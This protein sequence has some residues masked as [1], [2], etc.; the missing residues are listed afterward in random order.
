MLILR[1]L[2]VVRGARRAL[3]Y[4]LLLLAFA[5][6]YALYTSL[7]RDA[8]GAL[9]LGGLSALAAKNVPYVFY[10]ALFEALAAHRPPP[11][12]SHAADLADSECRLEGNYGLNDLDK[13]QQLS[14]HNLRHC[15]RVSDEQFAAL[16]DS[17]AGFVRA[18][19]TTVLPRIDALVDVGS[20]GI[21]TVGGA[22][23]SVLLLTMLAQL[24]NSGTTLPVEVFIPPSDEGDDEFCDKF[25]PSF[26]ARC[27]RFSDILPPHLVSSLD[28][29]SYQ[30]KAM[31]LVMSRFEHVLFLDADNFAM[32]DLDGVFDTEAY[33]DTGLVIWPDLWRRVTAP[34][35][36]DIANVSVDLDTR[37]RYCYDDV[38]P[39]SRY[40]KQGMDAR[41]ADSPI[42]FHDLRGTI[43]DPASESGQMLVDKRRHAR[44]LLLALYYNIHGPAWYYRMFSQGTAGEGDKETFVSAAHALRLPYYQVRTPLAFDGFHHDTKAFQGL[45]LLQHDFDQDYALHAKIQRQMQASH[46]EYARY[47]PGYNVEASF[48]EPFLKQ[49]GPHRDV[50]VDVMFLH[51]SFYKFDPWTLYDQDCFMTGKTHE[52]L[53]GY[54][55]QRRYDF[56]DFELFNFRTLQTYLCNEDSAKNMRKF[57]YLDDK[58]SEEDW[59][60]M[61]AY[62]DEHVRYLEQHPVE[63][64]KH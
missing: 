17:H 52:H 50:E 35:W 30:I 58:V 28:V 33:R 37:V 32:K 10:T 6:V 14:W 22:R 57:R 39:V 8:A 49:N 11:G 16:R 20:R 56:F 7:G 46:E 47:D 2:L 19:D 1:K 48:K 12:P 53:R 27:V 41:A 62:I 64:E 55:N 60:R 23:Y 26:N 38:S 9:R 29:K 21:V 25:A 31:A 5:V 13:L 40:Q 59:P 61:C 45:G 54:R 36:Y 18:L 24:R 42:P 15:Y 3:R 51:A 44:T 43:M 63:K 4:V 34:A